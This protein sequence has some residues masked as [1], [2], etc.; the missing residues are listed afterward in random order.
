MPEHHQELGVLHLRQLTVEEELG[1][2]AVF[3]S[4]MR[5]LRRVP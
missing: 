5:F 1:S 2:W 4:F 3:C